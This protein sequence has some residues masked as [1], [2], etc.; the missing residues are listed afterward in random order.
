M[1]GLQISRI[2]LNTPETR[3]LFRGIFTYDNIPQKIYGEDGFLVVN[4]ISENDQAFEK[5]NQSIGHWLLIYFSNN[6]AFFLDSMGERPE[7]YGQNILECFES[8]PGRQ[9]I[10]FS[11]PLQNDFSMACGAYIIMFAYYMSF[12]R[13]VSIIKSK[14]GT[15]TCRNDDIAYNFLYKLTGMDSFCNPSLCPAKTF[16][17]KCKDK[18]KC[19]T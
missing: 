9:M 19:H 7:F 2:L 13:G 5:Q 18:C 17:W 16:G 14:F 1:N 12:E 8:F 15:N 10:V 6:I 4:T 11:K 3:F